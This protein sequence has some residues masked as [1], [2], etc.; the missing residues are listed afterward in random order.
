[1]NQQSFRVKFAFS[2]SNVIDYLAEVKSFAVACSGIAA[3]N[4]STPPLP[5]DALALLEDILDKHV[6]IADAK[7]LVAKL[8]K[9]VGEHRDK[10]DL[11]LGKMETIAIDYIGS[12]ESRA[13]AFRATLEPYQYKKLSIV[14]PKP[15]IKIVQD[16]PDVG[17]IKVRLEKKI[18]EATS[19]QV[20]YTLNT[21]QPNQTTILCPDVFKGIYSII[22]KGLPVG[23]EVFVEIRGNNYNG[24][25]LW[26]Q[27]FKK[28]VN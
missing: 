21:G 19:Y 8:E 26:S 24:N 18:K 11:V 15:R 9:E 25:G 2:T 6:E 13:A 4:T 22:V 20:Q 12:D 28:I 23:Q 14:P 5:T 3:F 7:T 1:M 10:L 27:M 16:G 17:S